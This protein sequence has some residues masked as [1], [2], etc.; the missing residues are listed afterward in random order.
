MDNRAK[1]ELDLAFV[2]FS[3]IFC[4]LSGAPNENIVQNH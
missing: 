4:P 3:F 2:P 1:V